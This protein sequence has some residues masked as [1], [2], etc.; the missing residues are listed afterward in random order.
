MTPHD[1][2]ARDLCAAYSAAADALCAEPGVVALIRKSDLETLGERGS[3]FAGIGDEDAQ[4]RKR[5]HR[6]T[7]HYEGSQGE[8]QG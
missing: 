3:V 8:S 1:L 6:L 4:W 2:I 7:D 5:W